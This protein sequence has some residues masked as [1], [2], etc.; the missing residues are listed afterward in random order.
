MASNLCHNDAMNLN[1]YVE[2]VRRHLL[3]AAEAG[4]DE[5]R[6][7]AERLVAP[8]EA[9]LLLN[10]QHALSAAAE[11]ITM[12]LAPGSVELRLRGH[13]PEFVV[14]PPP[15]EP[16]AESRREPAVA[17]APLEDDDGA[18]WR[19][20]VRMPDRLKP[21]I[22]RAARQRGAVGERLVR[23]GGHRRPRAL[24]DRAR[25]RAP[26]TARRPASDRLGALTT[27]TT[28]TRTRRTPMMP[29]FQTPNPIPSTSSSASA[30]SASTPPS[31]PTP[32]SRCCPAIRS[33]PGDVTAAEQTRVDLAGARL[34][35]R[36]Q[37]GW[38]RVDA[39]GRPRVDRRAGLAPHR[40][41]D[42]GRRR[43]RRPAVARGALGAFRFKTGAGDIDV[44]QA[45]AIAIRT[46]AG[47]IV[48]GHAAGDLSASTG[49]G[50]VRIAA[51]DGSAVIKN[52]N[53]ETWVGDVDGD[54][55]VKA[56]NGSISVDRAGG[57][58][59]VKTANGDISLGEVA[60]GA[61]VAQTA[62]GKIDVGI[63]DGVAAWLD[64]NTGFGRVR[65]DLAD[66]ERPAAGEE[67]VEVRARTS[68]GDISIRRAPA[69]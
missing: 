65:N 3:L 40:L 43:R 6:A 61:V 35:I 17:P 1:P 9:A 58:V 56:A 10:L 55:R 47:D 50:V 57:T 41:G 44:D 51:V 59:T 37:R 2:D 42:P 67:T 46:G 32:L 13:D 23:P 64:L 45:G 48:V 66:T 19:I 14:T 25:R 69:A 62:F 49:S 5:A 24:R 30:T 26:R 60:P 28:T 16:V 12:E 8:L 27:T 20:N 63:R 29:T 11:E 31:A 18:L 4:G 7:V 21:S 15:G 52:S 22:E 68:Y 38:R 39:G 34:V 54:L 36:G 33:K 53:R